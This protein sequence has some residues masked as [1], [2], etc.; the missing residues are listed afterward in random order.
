MTTCDVCGVTVSTSGFLGGEIICG[1]C[2]RARRV[3]DEETLDE[4][5]EKYGGEE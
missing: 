5:Q 3:G 4:R 1:R 2:A